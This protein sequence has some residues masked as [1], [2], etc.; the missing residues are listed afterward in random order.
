[1]ILLTWRSDIKLNCLYEKVSLRDATKVLL[2]DKFHQ[3]FEEDVVKGNVAII[4]NSGQGEFEDMEMK[5]YFVNKKI[6]YVWDANHQ[7]SSHN[8]Q[9]L[10]RKKKKNQGIFFYVCN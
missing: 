1:M 8:I 10:S 3:I 2:K 7:V 5:T 4:R 6:K 9:N